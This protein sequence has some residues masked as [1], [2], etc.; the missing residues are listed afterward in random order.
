MA[1]ARALHDRML[2]VAEA[3]K[4]TLPQF[5]SAHYL[6]MC[7][8]AKLIFDLH[9]MMHRTDD[10]TVRNAIVTILDA[11]DA[12]L[13]PLLGRLEARP[14]R[15]VGGGRGHGRG[16]GR[17]AA[18]AEAQARSLKRECV[19]FLP[20][21][22]CEHMKQ[23]K[24]RRGSGWWACTNHLVVVLKETKDAVDGND[25]C[26]VDRDRSALRVDTVPTANGTS[27]GDD[28]MQRAVGCSLFFFHRS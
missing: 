16:G 3:A 10:E 22:F 5:S 19:R 27:R 9:A 12:G 14:R 24:K 28:G 23:Q 6:K 1:V 20:F 17:V 8:I 2:D 18:C 15:A 7:D 26:E 11:V 25:V 4:D 13:E 21:F